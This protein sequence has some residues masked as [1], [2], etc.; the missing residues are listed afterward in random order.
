LTTFGFEVPVKLVPALEIR[1]E[2]NFDL[3]KV[4]NTFRPENKD[5]KFELFVTKS[6]K[7][8][9]YTGENINQVIPRVDLVQVIY[10]LRERI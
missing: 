2:A 5:K 6:P 1:Y 7:I 9:S 4:I 8:Q 10:R 3:P